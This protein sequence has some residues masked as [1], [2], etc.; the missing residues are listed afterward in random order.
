MRL[1]F[2]VIFFLTNCTTESTEKINKNNKDNGKAS[3]TLSGISITGVVI[4]N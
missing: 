2:V 1:I 3:V 4:N